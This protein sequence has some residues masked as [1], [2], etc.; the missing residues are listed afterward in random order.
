VLGHSVLQIGDPW[1][2]QQLKAY[3]HFR[4]HWP[5]LVFGCP[6]TLGEVEVVSQAV[7]LSALST[8]QGM[9]IIV[10]VV[11][12]PAVHSPKSYINDA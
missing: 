12:C 6:T 2:G 10:Q 9:V 7:A 5:A 1:A 8:S 11:G 3:S 4:Q